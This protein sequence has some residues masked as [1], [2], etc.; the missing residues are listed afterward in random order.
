M[1]QPWEF[2]GYTK[3]AANTYTID[4]TNIGLTGSPMRLK[5]IAETVSS[6]TSGYGYDADYTK[7]QFDNAQSANW[8]YSWYYKRDNYGSN[9][10][11]SNFT[12][13][14]VGQ[15]Q[16]GAFNV[17]SW[18]NK[19]GSSTTSQ[20]YST[21]EDDIQWS[22]S[23]FTVGKQ[24][25]INGSIKLVSMNC[26]SYNNSG[27]LAY[28]TGIG[29]SGNSQTTAAPSYVRLHTGNYPFR[30]GSKF[31]IWGLRTSNAF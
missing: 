24:S 25:G 9:G 1:T 16:S 22:T 19:Q 4:F 31:W 11:C 30:A 20:R 14:S 27:G 18:F 26:S 8:D 12:T 17:G 7:M 21:A 10:A 13:L 23:E 6:S 15:G 29:S 28:N 3:L 2:L 5:I